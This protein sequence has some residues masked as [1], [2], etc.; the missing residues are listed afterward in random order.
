MVGA[1]TVA[2]D[3]DGNFTDG[4]WEAAL[5]LSALIVVFAT[6]AL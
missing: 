3:S 5:T 6:H 2:S 4:A 1:S